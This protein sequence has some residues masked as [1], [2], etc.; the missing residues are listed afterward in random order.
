MQYSSL[1]YTVEDRVATIMLNRPDHL[2]AIDGNMPTE[3]Q[4][5]GFKQAVRERDSSDPIAPGVSR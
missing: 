3:L 2:N 5:V 4:E 1:A